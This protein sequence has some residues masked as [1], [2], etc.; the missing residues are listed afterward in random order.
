MASRNIEKTRLSCISAIIDR[1]IEGQGIGLRAGHCEEEHL[2]AVASPESRSY[3]SQ[4]SS[5]DPLSEEF[6]E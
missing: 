5:I 4:R 1:K 3:T 6:N 2:D